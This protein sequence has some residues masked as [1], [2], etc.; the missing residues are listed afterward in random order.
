MPQLILAGDVEGLDAFEGGFEGPRMGG[1]PTRRRRVLG[2]RR[3]DR[4]AHLGAG[5]P[6]EPSGARVGGA[7]AGEV[8]FAA[9]GGRLSA[10]RHSSSTL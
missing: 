7:E 6:A 3:G 5:K 9:G 2:L 10:A 1:K 4:G 8:D